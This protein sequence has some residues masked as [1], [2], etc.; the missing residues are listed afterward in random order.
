MSVIVHTRGQLVTVA[1][2]FFDEDG[3]ATTPASPVLHYSYEIDGVATTGEAAMAENSDG[4]WEAAIDTAPADDCI[5]YWTIR[6]TGIA[7]EGNFRL[8]ANPA[9]PEI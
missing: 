7:T 1:A 4:E 9:N 2:T 8:V 6:A 3:V 5:V